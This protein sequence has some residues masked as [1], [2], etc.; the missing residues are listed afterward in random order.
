MVFNW[1]CFA[2]PALSERAAVYPQQSSCVF[3]S[4]WPFLTSSQSSKAWMLS[5]LV[6]QRREKVNQPLFEL[7]TTW[8]EMLR[9]SCEIAVRLVVTLPGESRPGWSGGHRRLNGDDRGGVSDG[10][11]CNKPFTL[12]VCVDRRLT[13][14]ER[15]DLFRTKLQT[16]ISSL[17]AF[18]V[19][20]RHLQLCFHYPEI[21]LHYW[22]L[23]GKK[24]VTLQIPNYH[25]EKQLWVSFCTQSGV[26]YTSL[27]PSWHDT[28]LI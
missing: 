23:R 10:A 3:S 6:R 21:P 18:L 27:S 22:F 7:T 1:W 2:Y 20:R 17:M 25:S 24:H 5:L 8:C 19:G 13:G 26:I 28:P 15:D 4:S 16:R 12:C 9:V 14:G 11:V